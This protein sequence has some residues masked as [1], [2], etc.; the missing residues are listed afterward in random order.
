MNYYVDF[1]FYKNTYHGKIN[2]EEFLE[3]LEEAQEKIDEATF[4]RI[5]GISFEN[6]T[7]FRQ[8]KIKKAMCYQIDY[9]SR[10]GNDDDTDD[11]SS[12]SVL[13]ISVT[14]DS[15]SKKEANKLNMSSMAYSLLKKTGLTNRSFK[16]H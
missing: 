5:V 14:V 8:E 2:K 13:D 1:D 11:I 9:I 10:N 12:Y 16:W 4:N 15:K 7:P 3:K 6:L